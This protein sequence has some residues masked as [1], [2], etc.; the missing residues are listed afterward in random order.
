MLSGAN[1]N[2]GTNAGPGA[3][4]LNN[5]RGNSNDNTGFSADSKPDLKRLYNGE[6]G[7][8]GEDFQPKAK[9]Y[10]PPRSGSVNERPWRG[11]L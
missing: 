1:W 8:E 5:F 11:P 2:N 3:V 4:N 7:V 10:Y 9:P 6:T